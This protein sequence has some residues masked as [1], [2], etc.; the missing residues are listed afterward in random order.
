M[1]RTLEQY[2]DWGVT[3]LRITV[4]VIFLMHGYQKLFVYGVSGV[5][6]E[7]FLTPPADAGGSRL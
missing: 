4:G 2:R 5:S 1:T 6:S 3:I 7:P